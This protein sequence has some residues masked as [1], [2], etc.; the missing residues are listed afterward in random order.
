[1]RSGFD[2]L[3]P[4]H[5]SS[6]RSNLNDSLHSIFEEGDEDADLLTAFGFDFSADLEA[7]DTGDP[8]LPDA[9]DEELEDLPEFEEEVFC[10]ELH[11]LLTLESCARYHRRTTAMAAGPGD[12][13]AAARTPSEWAEVLDMAVHFL[14]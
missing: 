11:E 8:L 13:I 9:G 6:N 1:M 12:P 7:L 14:S 10:N 2:A 4:I 5:R 3:S